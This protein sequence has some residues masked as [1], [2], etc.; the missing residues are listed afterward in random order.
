MAK[1]SLVSFHQQSIFPIRTGFVAWLF[2][3]PA[4]RGTVRLIY[5]RHFCCWMICL[6]YI[7]DTGCDVNQ[8]AM[9][10]AHGAE[11]VKRKNATAL[12][13]SCDC[14]RETYDLTR[15]SYHWGIPNVVRY[16]N[17]Y[18]IFDTGYNPHLL[19]VFEI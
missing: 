8:L 6:R 13:P 9:G 18:K 2:N 14:A 5:G 17:D 3:R 1:L 19:K 16:G 7:S 4:I 11:M 15:L 12:L 10:S